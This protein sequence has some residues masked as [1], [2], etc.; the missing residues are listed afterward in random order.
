MT[1]PLDHLKILDFST[2]LPGPYATMILA[3]LGADIIRIEAPNRPD[4]TRQ[5]P[6]HG[7]D[8][9]SAQHALLNRSKRSLGLNL[10]A[11]AAVEIVQQLVVEQGYD[12]IV[13]QFRPGVMARLGVGYEQ[14]KAVC[15]Q[16]IF[17]SLTGYGQ[18]GPYKDRAGHD[19]N[20]LALSGLLSYYGRSNQSPPPPP[21]PM[22][23][24]DI[25]GGSL[26]LVIGLLAAVIR[27]T[28]TGEG[29]QVDISMHDGALAWNGLGAS[30]F[31]V[32]AQNPAPEGE[33]LNGGSFYDIYE[34]ADGRFL[35]V[36][37]LEPKFWQGFCQ[38]IGREDL[39]APGLNLDIVHQQS[40]KHEI[41]QVIQSHTFDHWRNLFARLDVCVEPVLTTEEAVHHPQTQARNMIIDVPTNDG[42]PQQQVA[43]PI[44]LSDHTPAYAHSGAPL[45][46]HSREI[47]RQIGYAKDE[48]EALY[49][50][51]VVAG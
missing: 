33:L 10:K 20:Y 2:L 9:Q 15:P 46:W 45:G 8:G 43:S 51:N 27:R 23:V 35:A 31:L 29:A 4:L 24:A 16:L 48:I 50:Q 41:R 5:L 44:K 32:G 42:S 12:I 7:P 26:H 30:K 47:L 38:A 39:I 6:P 19:L 40:F 28:Q 1:A 21:L 36:G 13:E 25:G 18:T 37:P 3:D 22:Q 11:P 49:A 34:T 14:L 17:C